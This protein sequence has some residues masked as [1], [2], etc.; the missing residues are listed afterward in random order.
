MPDHRRWTP[1]SE[2][3]ANVRQ[4]ISMFC[5]TLQ[6]HLA[7]EAAS[8]VCRLLGDVAA[9]CVAPHNPD[10]D[11][12]LG[13]VLDEMVSKWFNS[14]AVT[15]LSEVVA[16]ERRLT[17]I[18]QVIA[19][20]HGELGREPSAEEVQSSQH[21]EMRLRHKDPKRHGSLVSLAEV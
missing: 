12:Y 8:Y 5:M 15:P 3:S 11:K 1:V 16:I 14:A 6:A 21:A 9:G 18:P 17:R 13:A 10:W 19:R 4:T 2:A 20:L 7:T